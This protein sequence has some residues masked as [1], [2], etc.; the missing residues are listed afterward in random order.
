MPWTLTDVER[1]KK[2]LDT[3]QKK[4][5]VRM[6]NAIFADCVK[7]K[8]KGGFENCKAKAVIIANSKTKTQKQESSLLDIYLRRTNE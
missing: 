8:D 7:R 6:A 1:H 5:W 4:K 3:T 2:N